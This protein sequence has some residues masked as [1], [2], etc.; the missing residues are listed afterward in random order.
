MKKKHTQADCRTV[1][2]FQLST[3]PHSRKG[4]EQDRRL[5]STPEWSWNKFSSNTDLQWLTPSVAH[6][7]KLNIFG[8]TFPNGKCENY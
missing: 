8:G 5:H 1:V 4:P 2:W 7:M 3:F 6:C